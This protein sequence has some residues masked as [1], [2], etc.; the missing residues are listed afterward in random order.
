[1]QQLTKHLEVVAENQHVRPV[2]YRLSKAARRLQWNRHGFGQD[3]DSS[4]LAPIRELILTR[5][6]KEVG[7]QVRRKPSPTSKECCDLLD[8]LLREARRE[9]DLL[10][11]SKLLVG[12]EQSL[13][14]FIRARRSVNCFVGGHS[15]PL[16]LDLARR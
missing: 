3:V 2:I 16:S 6:F 12:F 15:A 11:V 8:L 7:E 10:V 5:R 1:M 14:G 13:I 9:R 4:G